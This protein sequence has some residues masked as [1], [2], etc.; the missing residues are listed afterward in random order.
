[1]LVNRVWC[2][3]PRPDDEEVRVRMEPSENEYTE[4]SKKDKKKQKK[5]VDKKDGH[6]NAGLELEEKE[7]SSDERSKKTAL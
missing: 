7:S 1:M 6:S 4:P 5:K 3:K 2:S